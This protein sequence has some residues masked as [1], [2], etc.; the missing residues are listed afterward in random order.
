MGDQTRADI[1]EIYKLV[2][3]NPTKELLDLRW[4]A[5][6]SFHSKLKA[7]Q[8]ISLVRILLGLGAT[9]FEEAIVAKVVESDATFNKNLS[10]SKREIR[11][12]ALLIGLEALADKPER[13]ET[14]MMC[15]LYLCGSENLKLDNVSQYYREKCLNYLPNRS[16]QERDDSYASELE[17]EEAN[18]TT[19]QGWQ[20]VADYLNKANVAI[21]DAFNGLER[22]VQMY[23]EESNILWWL[24]NGLSETNRLKFNKLELDL[25]ALS[26]GLEIA[27][28]TKIVPGPLRVDH[29]MGFLI[30][31]TKT[32]ID[33]KKALNDLPLSVIDSVSG[34]ANS[35]FGKN[36]EILRDMLPFSYGITLRK[37]LNNPSWFDAFKRN[38]FKRWDKK[39]WTALMASTQIFRETLCLRMFEETN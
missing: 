16:L 38:V 39:N 29:M 34:R 2:K 12:L 15:L 4:N 6:K 27:E 8:A 31:E 7:V 11:A 1:S 30:G 10:A 33:I 13:T 21:E 35:G 25:R 18:V 36:K 17:I 5:I 23:R 37:E 19:L 14:L 22:K 24:M 32:K 26:A 9:D 3:I 20:Q 28:K